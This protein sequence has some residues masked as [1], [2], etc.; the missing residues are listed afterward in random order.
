MTVRPRSSQ[1]ATWLAA[2]ERR[3]PEAVRHLLTHDTGPSEGA[4]VRVG[5]Q[6]SE[7]MTRAFAEDWLSCKDI[8]RQTQLEQ[9]QAVR[10][11]WA[12]G[13]AIAAMVVAIAMPLLTV[14]LF[15]GK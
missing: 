8:E 14:W 15:R 3:G 7:H 5:A 6:V 1:E 2:M 13:L 10:D 9:K 4:S 12:R 11:W